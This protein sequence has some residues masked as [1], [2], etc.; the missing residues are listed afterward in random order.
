M[1]KWIRKDDHVLVIAGNEKGNTGVVAARKGDRVIVKGLNMRRKHMKR[2]QQNQTAG[3]IDF[4]A[5]IH[6]S[7]LCICDGEGNRLK[8]K[9]KISDGK[10]KDLVYHKND[11]EI[12][13][14]TIKK[15]VD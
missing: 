4:E 15:R 7:N 5:P 9:V 10:G 11:K 2:T 8:L 14:R 12:V 1:S 3:I 13:L 6:I